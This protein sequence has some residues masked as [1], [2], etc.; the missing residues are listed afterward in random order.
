MPFL[1]ILRLTCLSACVAL[2][3]G[4]A[5]KLH[6][7]FVPRLTQD[8]ANREASFESRVTSAAYEAKRGSFAIGRESGNVEI[9]DTQ[10][11]EKSRQLQAH[12][13]RVSS[14]TFTDDGRFFFTSCYFEAETKLW[15]VATG[16][17]VASIPETRGPE[18]KAPIKDMYVLSN[19][20]SI[21]LFDIRRQQL[22]P[23]EFASSGVVTSLAVDAAT[24]QV[25][26]G[27]ASG[28]LQ[29]WAM[30]K[31]DAAIPTLQ[32]VSSTSPYAMANWV[33][34]LYF[35]EG[36]TKLLSAT[37]GGNV[38]IWNSKTLADRQTFKTELQYVLSVDLD[39]A[40]GVLARSGTKD[41]MGFNGPSIET[42]KLASGVSRMHK[43]NMNLVEVLH[44][45]FISSFIGFQSGEPLVVPTVQ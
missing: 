45:P 20:S 29:V 39:E 7:E 35:V 3:A 4:C 41:E 22:L 11:G 26:V 16:A 34:G 14:I 15:N 40:A 23:G 2:M 12:G 37:R 21:R 24:R 18:I 27:T 8:L 9:W 28:T 44:L 5:T 38:D 17:L 33:I 1:T 13:N 43:T 10:A 30:P 32:L 19:S 6:P 31:D 36:G 42:L 25:A